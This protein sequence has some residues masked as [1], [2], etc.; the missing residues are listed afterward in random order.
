V[1]NGIQKAEI[2]PQFVVVKLA[3]KGRQVVPTWRGQRPSDELN[4]L[5]RAQIGETKALG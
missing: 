1:D 2:L 4:R 3:P 5:R